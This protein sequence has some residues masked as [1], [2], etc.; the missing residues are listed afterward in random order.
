[1][2]S[3]GAKISPRMVNL[4][5]PLWSLKY[6]LTW[7]TFEKR[8]TAYRLSP[9]T[10]GV[11]R[12]IS[13]DLSDSECLAFVSGYKN[14]YFRKPS[15]D[16][17]KAAD[18][19]HYRTWRGMIGFDIN[20]AHRLLQTLTNKQI[21]RRVRR[22]RQQVLD[23]EALV[24]SGATLNLLFP[25]DNTRTK[26][27]WDKDV[28]AW[29]R[30]TGVRGGG[31]TRLR[32]VYEEAMRLNQEE[33]LD[34]KITSE[35]RLFEELPVLFVASGKGG[36][37]KSTVSADISRALA[38]EGRRPLLVDVDYY[39]PSQ[40]VL[41]PV[42][43]PRYRTKGG[44]IVPHEVDGVQVFSLGHLMGKDEPL[45]WRGPYISAAIHMLLSNVETG[46]DI[47]IFDLPPGT[48]DVQ[49]DLVEMMPHALAL[50]VTTAAEIAVADVRR[51]AASM[52]RSFPENPERT[53]EVEELV[54]RMISETIMD[55]EWVDQMAAK[56]PPRES[57]STMVG[58]LENMAYIES[59]EGKNQLWGSE[60]RVPRLAN[61]LDLPFWGKVPMSDDYEIRSVSLKPLISFL[62]GIKLASP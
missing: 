61:E 32:R 13:R 47:V 21:V 53:K 60:K 39:G 5:E 48:G 51:A 38:R 54:N 7:T 33:R 19:N 4:I 11:I 22:Y 49:Q 23:G 14:T 1:M 8:G 6:S 16:F 15:S 24:D 12:F 59:A 36:V 17:V 3:W 58:I 62:T 34:V 46:A 27:R 28:L 31:A 30:K 18:F 52:L 10:A 20:E 9:E 2:R 40:H 25:L 26:G 29:V 44:K 56:L 35:F 45:E 55:Q 43:E 57:M 42:E 50:L 37:G 41:F